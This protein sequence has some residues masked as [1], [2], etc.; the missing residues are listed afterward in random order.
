[1]TIKI[2]A[3]TESR[4]TGL[5][6]DAGVARARAERRPRPRASGFS[7]LELTIAMTIF[8]AVSGVAFSLFNQEQ[9]ASRALQGRTALNVALRNAA[10]Q[11]Q[12]DIV[13]RREWILPGCEYAEL[14]DLGD[15][16]Q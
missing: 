11:L 5:P 12:M 14:A 1:M 6:A 13:K 16:P 10:A 8:V 3:K 15:H 2:A 9:I 4:G 7:L